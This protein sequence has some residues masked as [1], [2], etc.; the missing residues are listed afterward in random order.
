MHQPSSTTGTL[1]ASA[2]RSTPRDPPSQADD[3]P[4]PP[5]PEP[6]RGAVAQPAEERVGD[7][8]H[9]GRRPR[10]RAPGCSAPARCPTSELIFS[11]RVTSRGAMN[12]SEVPMYAPRVQRDEAPAHAADRLGLALSA[13]PRGPGCRPPGRCGSDI[14]AQHPH[15]WTSVGPRQG[16]R[17]P[18][19]ARGSR[20]AADQLL[21]LGTTT[22][23]SSYDESC[24]SGASPSW[25]APSMVRCGRTR[26]SQ[27]GSHQLALP[28]SAIVAGHQDHPDD[29]GVDRGSRWRARARAS[30][31]TA[32]GWRRS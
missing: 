18:A 14:G 7:H 9:A 6:R 28:S 20:S 2:T 21:G 12:T 16:C 4:R 15:P 19:D 31:A 8:R 26:S 29:G 13:G 22:D 23:A 17:G 30:S 10:P 5:H 25:A 32:P 3:H 11:A 24:P 1:G 27:A